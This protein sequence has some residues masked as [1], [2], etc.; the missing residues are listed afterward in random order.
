MQ[1]VA[2]EAAGLRRVRIKRLRRAACVRFYAFDRMLCVLIE[3]DSE[4][5]A[6]Y[7]CQDARLE[8]IGLCEADQRQRAAVRRR[9][10]A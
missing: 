5:D 6:R 1:S 4:E 3:A 2:T 9:N 7:L 8:F 10:K